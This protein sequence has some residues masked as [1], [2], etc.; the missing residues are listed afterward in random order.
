M[1]V[2]GVDPG[3]SRCGLGVVEGDARRAVVLRAGVVRT[4][5]DAP[6]ASRLAE[7]HAAVKRLLTE[8]RPDALAVERVFVRANVRTVMSVSQAIGVVLLAAAH[9][10]VPV[11]EYTP[12]QVKAAVAGHG[13]AEK[14]QVG[15]MVRALLGLDEVPRP[16]DVADALAVALCHLRAGASELGGAGGGALEAR[17]A[18]AAGGAGSV[19]ARLA[20]ALAD[21]GPGAQVTRPAGRG[22]GDGG[23]PREVDPDEPAGGSGR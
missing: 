2:I 8:H 19:S 5:A 21:A 22:R 6:T 3:L 15:Y 10:G 20:S 14:P 18:D 1:R 23:Q 17:R 4:D 13:D 16:P 9:T 7:V 12:T 11:A